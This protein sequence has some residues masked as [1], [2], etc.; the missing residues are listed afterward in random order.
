MPLQCP[1]GYSWVGYGCAAR[2]FDHHPITKPEKTQICYLCLKHLFLEGPF[3]KPMTFYNV[4]WDAYSTFWQPIGKPKDKF[5]ENYAFFKSAIYIYA[6]FQI[7]KGPLLNLRGR[8]STLSG[9]HIP[10]PTFLLST[11]PPGFSETLQLLVINRT[12][13]T[14]LICI[15]LSASC[16]VH[17]DKRMICFLSSL[18]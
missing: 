6:N 2:S 11:P 17:F 12:L 14:S 10:V 5:I 15:L 3:L 4:N 18:F 8:K 9:P 16:D 13:E 7:K 1:G